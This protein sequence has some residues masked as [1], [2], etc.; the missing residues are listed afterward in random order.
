MSILMQ[1]LSEA[2][3]GVPMHIIAESAAHCFPQDPFQAL[4][5]FDKDS[6][7]CPIGHIRACSWAGKDSCR[8]DCSS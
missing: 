8:A 2:L 3:V 6:E 7:G 5:W 4:V 1:F